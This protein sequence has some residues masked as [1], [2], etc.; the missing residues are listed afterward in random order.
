MTGIDTRALTK[1]L[2]TRGTM[3]GKIEFSGQELEFR[4]PNR[5]DLVAEVSTP[6]V[7]RYG[8]DS[9]ATRTIALLDC[10]CKHG[11]IRMILE[12]GLSVL[13]VPWNHDLSRE[14][15]DGLL[16]S[17]GPG[18]P[19]RCGP[20]IEQVR[21][22]MA[23]NVPVM[24]ICLGHQ[25]LALAAGATTYKLKFGHRSQNQPIQEAGT[26]R[27]FV[28]SQNHGYA[29]ALESI[30]A[31]WRPWFTN[32]NDGTNEGLIHESGRFMSV[33][34][35]PE[36]SPGPLDTAILFDRFVDQIDRYRRSRATGGVVK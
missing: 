32:L 14:S 15:F 29:V 9:A 24:G 22:V 34:F 19:T 1:K 18:D 8:G 6:R 5:E 28:T 27:C 31:G 33:Q 2:R 3:L 23:W 16:I 13:R 11:I 10:G 4:D 12:R 25:I 26:N 17:N 7:V 30:P 20:T 35:H 36:A 21:R